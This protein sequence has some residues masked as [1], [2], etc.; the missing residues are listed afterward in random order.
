MR[1]SS[2]ESQ[3]SARNP[4]SGQGGVSRGRAAGVGPQV[5]GQAEVQFFIG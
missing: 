5:G 4:E 2:G 1:L 3:L